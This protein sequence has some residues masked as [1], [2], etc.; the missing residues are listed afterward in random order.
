VRSLTSRRSARPRPSQLRCHRARECHGRG[1][2][3]IALAGGNTPK[4]TYRLL[5][6]RHRDEIE[7][8]SWQILFG[9]ERFVPWDDAR[10]NYKMARDTLLAE[11]PIPNDH[12]HPVPARM[13][14]VGGAADA[15]EQ[16]LR[17]VLAGSAAEH[18]AIDLVLLGV[19][20]DGHTVSL[21]PGS[22]ALAEE[23]RWACAVDAPTTV[24]PAVPRVTLTLPILN[25]ARNVIFL[26]AVATNGRSSPRFSGGRNRA[27]LSSRDGQ[28]RRPHA[29]DDRAVGDAVASLTPNVE[30]SCE[31]C[32][33]RP[34]RRVSVDC[35]A[36]CCRAAPVHAT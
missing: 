17:R 1:R 36:S 12:V 22:P 23:T 7:W 27:T 13:P 11:A 16:T 34:S 10:S 31:L 21:F 32:P 29:V 15:Y 28:R 14:T 5:V 18:G 20:P 8:P 6:E 33:R 2:F 24:Q 35:R 25:T 4:R 9:D 3:S 19:G 26:V 30:Y